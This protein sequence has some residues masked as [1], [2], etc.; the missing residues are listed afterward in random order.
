MHISKPEPGKPRFDSEATPK[1]S[2]GNYWGRYSKETHQSD[3]TY[4]K[5]SR[6]GTCTE[7]MKTYQ[8][9]HILIGMELYNERVVAKTY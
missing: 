9:E 6:I 1:N 2:P 7:E 8:V 3:E 5:Y 4:Y